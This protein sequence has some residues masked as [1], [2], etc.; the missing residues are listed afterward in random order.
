MEIDRMCENWHGFHHFERAQIIQRWLKTIGVESTVTTGDPKHYPEYPDMT[1]GP[2]QVFF[3]D[4]P[5]VEEPTTGTPVILRCA[6]DLKKFMRRVNRT[7][8]TLRK[9]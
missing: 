9:T 5:R 8:T 3:M 1:I 7:A 6:A 4:Y 2:M